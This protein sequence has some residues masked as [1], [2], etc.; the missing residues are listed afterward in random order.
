MVWDSYNPTDRIY[1][2]SQLVY[3]LVLTTPEW[4]SLF[5]PCRLS[6]VLF[7][8][9]GQKRR[10]GS[11]QASMGQPSPASSIPTSK[12][13]ES[14]LRPSHSWASLKN[15]WIF[16]SYQMAE[17]SFRPSHSPAS[18]TNSWM[19]PS[20]KMAEISL[21]QSHLCASFTSSWMFSASKKC[22]K[23][24][25]AISLASASYE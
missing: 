20:S 13:A 24:F 1:G 6:L 8:I 21:R 22:W 10:R 17:S 25:E 15:S 11:N 16:P 19:F 4:F 7:C 14:S 2:L 3:I 5:V 9:I 23:Q 18:L 12:M